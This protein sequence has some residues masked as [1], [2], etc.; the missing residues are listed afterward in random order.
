MMSRSRT[1]APTHHAYFESQTGAEFLITDR[2][3]VVFKKSPSFEEVD[4]FAGRYGLVKKAVFGDLDYL[5]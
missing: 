4:Q 5:F 3:L 1:I 2:I